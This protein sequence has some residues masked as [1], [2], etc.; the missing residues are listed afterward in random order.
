MDETK[1]THVFLLVTGVVGLLSIWWLVWRLPDRKGAAQVE[2]EIEAEVGA[3]AGAETA[4]RDEWDGQEV[5]L[6]ALDTGGGAVEGGDGGGGGGLGRAAGQYTVSRK[7]VLKMQRKKEKQER[8]AYFDEMERQRQEKRDEAL[9][10]RGERDYEYEALEEEE[11]RQREA[12]R[13]VADA[14]KAVVAAPPAASASNPAQMKNGSSSDDYRDVDTQRLV[15]HLSAHGPQLNL[16]AIATA[17][18][19]S[20]LACH[21]LVLGLCQRPS[22]YPEHHL[23]LDIAT[24]SIFYIQ[25]ARVEL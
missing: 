16:R 6:D 22:H 19:L 21:R 9:R 10:V 8:R 12:A 2:A 15:A 13:R 7:A 24:E 3:E 18:G 4:G 20:L 17:L 14:W 25:R 1:L 11:Q 5:D 23:H